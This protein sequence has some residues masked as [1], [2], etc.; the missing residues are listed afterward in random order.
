VCSSDLLGCS[1]C[2][3]AFEQ[4][5]TPLIERAQEGGASHLGK[6]PKNV[7]DMQVRQNKLAALRKQLALALAQE[8]YEQAATLRDKIFDVDP[9]ASRHPFTP[10]DTTK[11]ANDT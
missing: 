7:G 8:H 4:Q 3:A 10:A 9:N 6:V 11:S 2:Y 1:Q 5:L